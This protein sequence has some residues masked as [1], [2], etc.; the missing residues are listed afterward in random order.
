M[1]SIPDWSVGG[2]LPPVDERNPVSR[3]RSPY[4]TT[5]RELIEQFAT[6]QRRIEILDGFLRFRKRLHAC[7]IR[8]GV[9]W[10]NGS[11]VEK[12]EEIRK[13]PPN[14][15]DVVTILRASEG[16]TFDKF[17]N[18]CAE[19]FDQETVKKEFLTD[20]Y[21]ILIDDGYTLNQLLDEV[22]YWCGLWSHT[23]EFVW[24]GFLQIP[25]SV[26]FCGL[27]C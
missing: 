9:Q 7:G 16:K 23:R 2:F 27:L 3:N 25:L 1:L 26:P 17:W 19:L 15:V 12:K 14:D 20:S 6:T 24:K 11:F 18:S 10:I 8:D 21:Y 4:L 22:S 5:C 13:E